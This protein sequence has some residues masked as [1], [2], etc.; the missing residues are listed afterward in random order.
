MY[1]ELRGKGR[2]MRIYRDGIWAKDGKEY[3]GDVDNE[4]NG[5]A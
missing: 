4:E 3:V 1:V 5:V 2:G